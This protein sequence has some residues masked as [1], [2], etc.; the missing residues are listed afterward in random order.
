MDPLLRA[1][2]VYGFVLLVLRL[3]GKR[4]I[5][6]ITI[7]DLV[8]LLI[9][10]EATQQALLGDDFSM[11]NSFI[12]VTALIGT[13]R[14]LQHLEL[15][16]ERVGRWLNDTP[17]VLVADGRPDERRLRKSRVEI[18]D[19]LEAGRRYFGLE[20]LEEVKYAVLERDG[21]ISIIPVSDVLRRRAESPSAGS[22]SAG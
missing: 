5:A 20:R 10:S 2:L 15:R 21:G 11:T 6:Q 14:L 18:D 1:L 8:L 3:M 4:S 9:I 22:R 19:V 7:F 16:S 13:D 12:V 17:L